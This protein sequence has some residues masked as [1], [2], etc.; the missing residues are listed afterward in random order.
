[1]LTAPERERERERER[2][3]SKT[4]SYKDVSLGSVK[5]IQQLVLATKLLMRER[6]GG[7][8]EGG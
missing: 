8:G 7:E 2:E 6:E 5:P 4:L 3:N 1:M